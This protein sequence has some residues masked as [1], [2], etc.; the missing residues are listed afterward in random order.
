M[1]FGKLNDL[2]A[3]TLGLVGCGRRML[4]FHEG[5]LTLIILNVS[6]KSKKPGMPEK[7]DYDTCDKIRGKFLYHGHLY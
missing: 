4:N 6:L 2:V 3:Q 7:I 5:E 1:I